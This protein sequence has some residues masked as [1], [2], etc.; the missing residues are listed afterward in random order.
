[1]R[2]YDFQI[3]DQK[4]KLY[5]QY[6]SLDAYGN[7]N[8]GCL[9]VEFD[10]QRYGMSTPVGSSLVRVFGVSIKEMQQAEQNMFGMTIKGFVG[11]S[12][13]LPLA[14]SSQSGMILEG[15]IQQP[16]G[17]WQGLELSLDMIITAGAGSVDNPANITMPW[18]KGQK[19]SVALFF[20]LQR[21][22]PGYKIN[23]NISDLLVLNYDSPIYCS[24]MQQLA[25]NLKNLSRSI[26]RDE[27]YLG[28]EM[29]MFP[30][31]EI[32]V[33]DSAATEKKKTPIQLEFTDLVGQPVWIEYNRVM[34]T[35]VMRADIQV[36]DYVRMPAGAMAVTQ[37]SSYSQYR[38][39]SAFSG[40]FA[41]Q[42]CRCVG[43][44]RQPDAASWV[45]IYE[46]YVT[47]EA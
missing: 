15:I 20:A 27:N 39:K 33:W 32:R 30:G 41:V 21:A 4:G 1:M 8:P 29:A 3:F 10:I 28:V 22:F 31:K 35:C 44:S 5:R 46:A 12:K 24:T 43:N 47:Q 18:I 37:A 38:S 40:V 36:G 6:K 45:T 42:T 34:I 23:I 26:I 9:M 14:K 19:L 7:Y 13:G 17:N 25:S 16:F 11:M 2:Y